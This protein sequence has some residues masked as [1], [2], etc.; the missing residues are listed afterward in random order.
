MQHFRLEFYG[1]LY[2]CYPTTLFNQHYLAL[3]STK[4]AGTIQPSDIHKYHLTC[5][6]KELLHSLFPG[7]L[8]NYV[9]WVRLAVCSQWC[10]YSSALLFPSSRQATKVN[11]R[12]SQDWWN[13]FQPL[14]SI[15]NLRFEDTYDLASVCGRFA[16]VQLHAHNINYMNI[17]FGAH[18]DIW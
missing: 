1:F 15:R 3:Q 10:H 5:C 4:K 14:V 9:A 7:T 6:S 2:W 18:G 12:L 17:K 13:P 8:C 11:H 16:Y